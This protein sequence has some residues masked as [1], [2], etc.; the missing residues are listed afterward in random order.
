LNLVRLASQAV[1]ESEYRPNVDNQWE[2]QGP[3]LMSGKTSYEPGDIDLFPWGHALCHRC[4]LVSPALRWAHEMYEGQ[5]MQYY[6]W[7]VQQTWL[8]LGFSPIMSVGDGAWPYLRDVA[9]PEFIQLRQK[10][11]EARNQCQTE[12]DR[13][14]KMVYGSDRSDIGP[15]EITYMHNVRDEDA[16][17]M[18]RLRR[19]ASRERLQLENSVQDITRS[20][21]GQRKV[22]ERWVS[23]TQ[24]HQL[25]VALLPKEEI[26]RHDRQVLDVDGTG[27][28]LELDIWIPKRRIGIEYQGQ[29]HFKSIKAWGGESALLALQRRD[30]EKRQLCR[31][32]GICLIEIDYTEPLTGSHISHRLDL[33][34]KP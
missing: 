20:E 22:G 29:Q 6:G 27:R 12:T 13:V 14:M 28:G 11:E 9:P 31:K 23:E 33:K 21:F 32:L 16:A 25:V 5:F 10:A 17:E 7:Y 4:H 26:Y 18:I 1:A 2:K 30:E 24:L 34:D 15:H 8:R 19:I 3:P